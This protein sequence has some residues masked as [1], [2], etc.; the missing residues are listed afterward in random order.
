[1]TDEEKKLEQEIIARAKVIFEPVRL[2]IVAR[3]DDKRK[4]YVDEHSPAAIEEFRE[5]KEVVLIDENPDATDDEIR[6]MLD[7]EVEKSYNH[8]VCPIAETFNQDND[9]A[10]GFELSEAWNDA[11]TAARD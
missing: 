10:I 4:A 6:A 1:M 7:E 8:I 11:L 2:E 5:E 9:E 3:Y